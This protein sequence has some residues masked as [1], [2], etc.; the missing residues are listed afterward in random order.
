MKIVDDRKFHIGHHIGPDRTFMVDKLWTLVLFFYSKNLPFEQ[1]CVCDS[2]KAGFIVFPFLYWTI[3][4]K[5]WECHLFTPPAGLF[6]PFSSLG[7]KKLINKHEN[8]SPWEKL[9]E[10]HH[11]QGGSRSS[12]LTFKCKSPCRQRK[13][14]GFLTLHLKKDRFK[15]KKNTLLPYTRC[16]RF[17]HFQ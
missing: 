5:W 13:V 7:K 1:G 6:S 17:D 14:I 4:W 10:L 3:C 11:K 16:V 15:K 2:S 9:I 12:P 8:L